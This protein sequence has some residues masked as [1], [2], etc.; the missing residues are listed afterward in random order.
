MAEPSSERRIRDLAPRLTGALS[1]LVAPPLGRSVGPLCEVQYG[2]AQEPPRKTDQSV[3]PT[4]AGMQGNCQTWRREMLSQASRSRR[5]THRA[6]PAITIRV[7]RKWRSAHL[8]KLRHHLRVLIGPEPDVGANT[9]A[10]TVP[11]ASDPATR[12]HRGAGKLRHLETDRRAGACPIMPVFSK[13][14]AR[15]V[16]RMRS[17][18]AAAALQLLGSAPR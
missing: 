7:T 12:A 14:T 2:R 11:V 8:S 13:R 1:I 6:L 10:S 4:V 9:L 3:L 18:S 17:R 15:P 5:A 16:G